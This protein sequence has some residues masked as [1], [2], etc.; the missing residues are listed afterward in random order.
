M[1][2]KVRDVQDRAGP[3]LFGQ[4]HCFHRQTDVHLIRVDL[5]QAVHQAAPRA[6][7]LDERVN[8]GAVQPHPVKVLSGQGEGM[9]PAAGLHVLVVCGLLK[10]PLAIEPGGQVGGAAAGTP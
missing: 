9:D 2:R 3:P 8:A 1:G 5:A 4:E 6:V 7:D 10:A